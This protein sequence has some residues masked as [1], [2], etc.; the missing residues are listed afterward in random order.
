MGTYDGN[1]RDGFL[2][3]MEYLSAISQAPA[4]AT[5]LE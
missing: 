2:E 3:V 5:R 1:K 4:E